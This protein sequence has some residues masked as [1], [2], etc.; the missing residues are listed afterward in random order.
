MTKAQITE[1]ARK[2]GFEIS[3]ITGSIRTKSPVCGNELKR[4][5]DLVVAS[6]QAKGTK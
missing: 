6:I 4:F 3:E 2:A 5:A 1:L